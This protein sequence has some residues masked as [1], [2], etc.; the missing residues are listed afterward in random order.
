MQIII[1]RWNGK[2]SKISNVKS[3][4]VETTGEKMRVIVSKWREAENSVFIY[5]IDD[6][7]S[8]HTNM[9]D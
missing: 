7:I 6:V 5:N 8:V 1:D 3:F 4:T 2:R 9:Y